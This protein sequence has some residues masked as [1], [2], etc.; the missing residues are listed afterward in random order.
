MIPCILDALTVELTV[1][2]KRTHLLILS[3]SITLSPTSIGDK[4]DKTNSRAMVGII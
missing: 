2:V 1:S 3:K 4:H